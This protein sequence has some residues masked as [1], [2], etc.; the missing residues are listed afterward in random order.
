MPHEKTP[1]RLFSRRQLL[2]KAAASAAVAAPMVMLPSRAFASSS[3]TVTVLHTNDT[4]S[5]MEPFDKGPFKGK[6]GVARRM[7]LIR[8]VRKENPI[9]YLFDAGDTFQGTPWFNAFQGSVDIQ[10]M[11]KLGYDATAVGNH[12]FDAGAAKLSENLKH[13]PTLKA[14]AANFVVGDGS[15]LSGQIHPHHVFDRGG[16]KVGVFGLGVKF[17]GLVH[18]KLHPHID[19]RAPV[20][21]AREQVQLLREQGCQVIVALSHLGYKGYGG[22]IGDTGW[23]EKVKG[24]HYVVGGHSHTF[25]KKPKV[26]RHASGW[27]THVMQVG[28]SGLNLGR[29][30]LRVDAQGRVAFQRIRPVGVGGRAVV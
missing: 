5:R 13:H 2:H 17:D 3:K 6:A 11:K 1:L 19:W 18:P 21:V 29:A 27:E 20:D 16:V 28:H 30:D 14:L 22:E 24:V 4:H 25:L 7:T 10:V 26:V 15:E 8:K 12:D 23:P 9:T